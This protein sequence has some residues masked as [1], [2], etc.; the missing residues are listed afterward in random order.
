[1]AT[2]TTTTELAAVNQMLGTI[3]EAPLNTLIGVSSI[4]AQGAIA[5]LSEVSRAVQTQGHHFN[6]EVGLEMAPDAFNGEIALPANCLDID[7][8]GQDAALDVTQR[9]RRL[10]DRSHHT[11]FFGRPVTVDMVVMLPFDE[12]PESA[13]RYIAVRACRLFQKR[14]VGS[15]TLEAFSAADEQQALVD[16]R[17]A[18][19]RNADHNIFNSPDMRRMLRR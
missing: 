4:D 9:G 5:V 10:Y 15:V 3:M 17:R 1:M 11:Y 8:T 12:L 2:M 18:L 7:T 19:G 14:Q 6:T 13:R 16:F